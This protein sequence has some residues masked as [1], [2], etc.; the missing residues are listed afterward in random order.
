M[1]WREPSML[2]LALL[3]VPLAGLWWVQRRRLG[4]TR[5]TYGTPGEH[6]RRQGISRVLA[7]VLMVTAVIALLL[8]VAGPERTIEK[9]ER[10]NAV[11]IALDTSKSM[12]KADPGPSR[13]FAAIAAARKLL[14][15]APEETAIGLVTFDA[16]ARLVV[17]P[18]RD[19]DSVR[20]ALGRL[21]I[22][23]GTALGEAVSVSV[24]A[25]KTAGATTR[26]RRTTPE[27]SP[28]RVLVITDGVNSVGISP[29]IGAQR[30]QRA[31]TPVYT[32]LVGNDP[33][34]PDQ[35][36]PE[37]ALGE[38]AQKTGG[39]FAQ[40]SSP[41]ALQRAFNNFGASIVPTTVQ[42]DLAPWLIG[43]ALAA[44]LLAAVALLFGRRR[45][46]RA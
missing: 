34:R 38:I 33:G 44:L 22:G 9:D 35:P 41:A 12:N 37:D 2:W 45:H 10:R 21:P 17:A 36:L 14:E 11:I 30:A 42:Q 3:L 32:V 43:G 26:G 24:S 15:I 20:R 25:L 29:T 23:E 46:P 28:G 19:R 31:G 18:T 5:A 16:Q 40:T 4:H 13:S 6:S 8:A 27:E 39:K 7:G 1:S